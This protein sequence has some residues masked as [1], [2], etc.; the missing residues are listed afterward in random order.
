VETTAAELPAGGVIVDIGNGLGTQDPV[1]VQLLHPRRLVAVNIA[2]WQ[3]AAGRNRLA[4]AGAAPVAGD[5]AHCPSPR[6]RPMGLSAWR[7]RFTSG[8]ERRS[9]RSA[10]AYFGPAACCA[11][12]TS[13]PSAC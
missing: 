11:S 12:R 6:A 4:A 7:P 3:L 2:E 13:L 1:L 9:S 8:R 5:A 10:T